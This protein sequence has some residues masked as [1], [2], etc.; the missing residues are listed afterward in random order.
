MYV[1]HLEPYLSY[2]NI[3]ENSSVILSYLIRIASNIILMKNGYLC[4]FT[5]V[6]NYCID[7]IINIVHEH[8]AKGSLGL[9]WI[10]PQQSTITTPTRTTH[11]S[12]LH[13]L[14]HHLWDFLVETWLLFR[15]QG[16]T[17]RWEIQEWRGFETLRNHIWEDAFENIERWH[18]FR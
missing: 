2:R 13:Q 9:P 11:L 12:A 15:T 10:Q 7:I 6:I 3:Y 14:R 17:L 16:R 8:R 5:I 18:W 4:L 1:L